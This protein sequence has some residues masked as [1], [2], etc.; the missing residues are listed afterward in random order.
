[1]APAPERQ[2]LGCGLEAK[3]SVYGR[4]YRGY[5]VRFGPPHTP[6]VVKTL[7]IANVAVFVLQLLTRGT[8]DG[9]LAVT[10]R[11]F[12]SGA[13]W[14]PFTYMW[15]HGGLMHIAFNMFGLWM[16]GSPLA[17]AWGPRRFL[18]YYLLCG[19]GAGLIIVG[20]STGAHALGMTSG[21]GMPTVGA[22][23][24]IMGVVL[25]YT[26][27]WP[28]RTIMLLFPPIPIKAIWFVPLILG[29]ELLQNDPNISHLGHLGGIAVGW[30][31][32]RRER[33]LSLL[34]SREQLMWR[35]RRYKMRRQLHAV[36][37]DEDSW[38]NNDRRLH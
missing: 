32:F 6:D 5:E 26:L 21:Y 36:R 24:A 16:F 37:R 25:G 29:I 1:M 17:E 14:Q 11:F 18:R 12:W 10:P 34:P 20:V 28:D 7:L 4:G 33:N 8:L 31:L 38:R 9:L 3:G 22:S 35:W 2:G 13:L 23:G 15:L 19:L 27:T 30:V